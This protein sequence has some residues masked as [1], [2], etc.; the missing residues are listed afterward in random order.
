MD[1]VADQSPQTSA[2][3]RSV[4]TA[5]EVTT[6]VGVT[7]Q[8]RGK[9][10]KSK[11][12]RGTSSDNELNSEENC[13]NNV[14]VEANETAYEWLLRKV[15]ENNNNKSSSEGKVKSN[16]TSKSKVGKSST[17]KGVVKSTRKVAK[18]LRVLT[19][20]GNANANATIAKTP[21]VD[22]P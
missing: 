20:K 7:R 14:Q 1:L 17:N 13:L 22:E 9:V 11:E 6:Q 5:I 4:N 19:K 15:K 10:N 2:K 18:G 8:L 12:G 16:G 21:I 3:R